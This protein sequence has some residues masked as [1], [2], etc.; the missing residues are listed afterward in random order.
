MSGELADLGVAE[1]S[2]ALGAGRITSERLT[3]A[4]LERIAARDAAFGAWLRVDADAALADARAA[5][6]RRAGGDAGPLVG[7]PVGLKD[8]IGVA[9][10]PL[11]ADSALLAGNVAARDAT[12]WERLRDAG[13]VL[14]GHLHCGELACGAW[15]RNPWDP[16]FSPGGSSS[17]SALALATRTVPATLGS[18]ARGSIREPASFTGVTGM[19]PSFG[20]V[21]TA[22]CIPFTFSF[23]VVGPMARSALDCAL[24]LQALAGPDLADRASLLQPPV[25]R[26]PTAPRGGERPLAGTRIGV[27]RFADGFLAAGVAAVVERFHEQLAGLGATLVEIHRVHDPLEAGGFLTLLAGEARAVLAQLTGREHL[28][29]SEFKELFDE[30]SEHVG[31]AVD[32]VQG[33]LQRAELV[34]AWHAVFAAHRLDAVVEPGSIAEIYRQGAPFDVDVDLGL[35]GMW[36]D[37]NFPVLMLP[38]GVSPTDGGPVGMQV[39][40]L[41]FH[42]ARLLQVGI[43]YQAATGYHMVEPPLLADVAALDP[44]VGPPV[45]DG[46]PQP[47]WVPPRNMLDALLP[48]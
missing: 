7:V 16:A 35:Y 28:H 42:D 38:A 15:G 36:S 25:P 1:A 29:R 32:Y 18:D 48:Q 46:E 31:S 23:D 24:L 22:G 11:T 37:A 17:G 43:D 45:P 13:M 33:Q 3:E 5:D 4:C 9:G 20:L 47:A 14:L 27:P 34:A 21:S 41:P 19:K 39:V 40:G 26:Y 44:Y 12:A 10:R 8:L 6:A 30:M 2:E